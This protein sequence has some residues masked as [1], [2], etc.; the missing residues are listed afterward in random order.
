MGL[1]IEER[2]AIMCSE[3]MR[4]T[5]A[6][7]GGSRFSVGGGTEDIF[8]V[9]DI[10]RDEDSPPSG[11]AERGGE[12]DL[13]LSSG[14]CNGEVQSWLRGVLLVP[15][16][17]LWS[18]SEDALSKRLVVPKAFVEPDRAEHTTATFWLSM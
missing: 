10:I 13:E 12:L 18:A 7:K 14:E 6:K 3:R 9:E 17:D 5:V 1:L 8:K 4:S 11:R 15:T 2:A 16:A